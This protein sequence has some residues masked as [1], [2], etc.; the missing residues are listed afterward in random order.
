MRPSMC[1][2]LPSVLRH[3]WLDYRNSMQPVETLAWHVLVLL[4]KEDWLIKTHQQS[5]TRLVLPGGIVVSVLIVN[6]GIPVMAESDMV[7]I[8]GQG[9]YD[10]MLQW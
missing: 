3:C 9:R 1:S 6:Q 2:E 10:T 4:S 8:H 5:V 7:S